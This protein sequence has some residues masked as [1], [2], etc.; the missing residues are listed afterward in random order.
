MIS[1]VTSRS[2]RPARIATRLTGVTRY[3]SITPD[4]QSEMIA[5]PTNVEPNSA[6]WISSPGTKNRYA[7]AVPPLPDSEPAGRFA[8]SG[9]NSTRYRI[10]CS[11]PIVR[12]AGLRSTSRTC[13][14]KMNSVSWMNDISPLLLASGAGARQL[15]LR[16]VSTGAAGGVVP[17]RP[18]GQRQEH[19]VERR[20]GQTDRAHRDPRAVQHPQQ[21]RQRL[22]AV[23]YRQSQ[24]HGGHRDL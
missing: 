22:L 4:R 5:N 6:S 16:V 18:P 14:R 12:N 8:S 7:F 15:G 2:T 19:V 21:H 11:S 1:M 20:P 13:R 10:G 23:L 3:R 9:P 17:Q 24:C